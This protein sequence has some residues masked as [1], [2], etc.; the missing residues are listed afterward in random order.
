MSAVSASMPVDAQVARGMIPAHT[1]ATTK[2]ELSLFATMLFSSTYFASALSSGITPQH[3]AD[4]EIR[5]LVE[6][7]C[8]IFVS[9]GEVSKVSIFTE[10]LERGFYSD[11]EHVIYKLESEQHDALGFS[12]SVHRV[13]L[14]AKLRLF[15]SVLYEVKDEV[16]GEISM[17]LLEREK[18]MYAGLNTLLTEVQERE[19]TFRDSRQFADLAR[20]NYDAAT[21]GRRVQFQRTG[22]AS[23]DEKIGGFVPGRV[24]IV[25]ARPSHGKTS[26]VTW[27]SIL[28]NEAWR[29]QNEDGQVLYFSAEMS[30][31]VMADRFLSSLSGVNA[32]VIGSGKLAPHEKIKVEAALSRMN[33][34]V[35]VSIDTHSSPT[36]SYMMGR[37]LAQNAAERVRLIIFDYLEY[38]GEKDKSKDLRLEKALIGCHEIAKRIGCPFVVVSQLNRDIEK[39]GDDARPQLSDI[40][41]SGAAENVAGLV[42]MLYH[43]WTHFMQRGGDA[44]GI[45]EPDEEHYELL[46]RKNTMGPIGDVPLIFKRESASFVDPVANGSLIARNP[47]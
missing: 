40:R 44:K 19:V 39:R 46:L 11:T 5:E 29:R 24:V 2:T 23:L 33:S 45:E 28:H 25:A 9:R 3:F 43:P 20:A 14:S 35:R 30:E 47:F 34:D 27:L 15:H 7:A 38:T 17:S 8:D 6:I 42:I 10:A 21:Q 16:F 37:A 41:Y 18:R 1:L 4:S 31:E 32:R 22:L 12:D 36:T 26:F 13:L